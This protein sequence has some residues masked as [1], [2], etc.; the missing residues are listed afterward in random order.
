MS[1]I[2]SIEQ[3]LRDVLAPLEPRLVILF[4]SVARGKDGPDSDLDVAMLT[5]ESLSVQKQIEIIDA[6]TL[7]SGRPVDLV[8][9]RSVG[10]P[11]LGRILF[12]G[13]RL[14]GPASEW[15]RLLSRHLVDQADFVPLQNHILRTR[16]EAWTRQL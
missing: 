16:R 1:G 13:R 2:Y 14:L 7:A 3:H 8:D 11:L 9:L 4:G 5:N 12:E 15:G 10:E 6:L